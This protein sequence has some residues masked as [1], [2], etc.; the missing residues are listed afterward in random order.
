MQPQHCV[1]AQI[2]RDDPGVGYLEPAKEHYVSAETGR[3]GP[4][5]RCLHE[6]CKIAERPSFSTNFTV[7]W[8]LG[9]GIKTEFRPG[10]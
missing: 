3:N 2:G 1:S 5:V 6:N 8:V 9:M 7:S 4:G 10:V